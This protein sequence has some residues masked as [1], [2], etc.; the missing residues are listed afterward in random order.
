ML[1]IGV[2]GFLAFVAYV[3]V[4]GLFWRLATAA[5]VKRN[6]DSQLAAAMAFVY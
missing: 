3:V 4:Y 1:T 6:P 2:P 5:L